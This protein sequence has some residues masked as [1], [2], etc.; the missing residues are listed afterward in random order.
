MCRPSKLGKSAT[1]TGMHVIWVWG[2]GDRVRPK[3]LLALTRVRIGTGWPGT[4]E[5]F[6]SSHESWVWG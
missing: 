3:H 2:K 5:I 6:I 1:P 4:D